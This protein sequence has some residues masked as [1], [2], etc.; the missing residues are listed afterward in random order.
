MTRRSIS[1]RPLL[2]AAGVRVLLGAVA[3]VL[4][5]LLA[6]AP[7]LAAPKVVIISLDGATPSSRSPTSTAPTGTIRPFRT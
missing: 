5:A 7:A 3:G 6:A 1:L 2:S 4:A